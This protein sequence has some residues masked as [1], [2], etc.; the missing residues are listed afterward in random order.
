[1]EAFPL[2][3]ALNDGPPRAGTLRVDI[4][5]SLEKADGGRADRRWLVEVAERF[6][7]LGE[8]QGGQRVEVVVRAIPSGLA[9]QMFAA[10]TLKAAAYS[11][12]STQ[13]LDLLRHQGL[14]TRPI[15]SRLVDNGSVIAVRGSVWRRLRPE[16]PISFAAVVQHT[17]SGQL[18]M[19]YCNPYICSPGLDFLHT[20]LWLSAG[21]SADHSPLRAPDLSRSTVTA[22]FDL[23]QQRLATT[24]PTYV[25]A[26]Q[27]W[28]RDPA[29]F[30]AAVMAH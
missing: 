27:I 30:D 25:E 15:R 9:A 13:W 7:Q 6:N 4:V 18:R 5:S 28:K 23:F 14:A 22:S 10:G 21:H 1:V 3:G 29:T 2:F 24:T 16:G 20:L 17:L 11:P 19:A 8:R 26:I 12:A